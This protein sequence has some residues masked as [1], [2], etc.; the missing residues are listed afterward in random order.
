VTF[1]IVARD[2][3]SF[4]VA[5]ASKFLAAG[6]YVPAAEAGVGAV[7]SQAFSNLAYRPAGLAHLRQGRSAAETVAL[8][9]AGDDDRDTRQLGVVGRS[10]PGA[11]FTGANCHPWAGGRS[12]E[13]Y[14]VQGNIL[15]GEEVVLAMER[16]WLSGSAEVA[17][18]ATRFAW[19]LLHT[20]EAGDLAGG[21]RRGRQSAALLVASPGAGY[22][23]SDLAVD[24]RVDDHAQPVDELKRLL[25]L[26]DFYFGQPDPAS[27]L[28]LEGE[29]LDEVVRLLGLV[30][31]PPASGDGK[32][33]AE[34]LAE[35]A[36]MENLE[37]RYAGGPTLD[38]VVLDFLREK[39]SSGSANPKPTSPP[40]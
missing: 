37:M 21:D 9:T 3:D 30:G 5:V 35:W 14:A 24:L 2:G 17:N 11:T 25:S 34:A 40:P 32:A 12:G 8:L 16:A 38:P 33:V 20:L 13:G 19:R 36:S 31:F 7:A 6:A 10:G 22:G 29:I 39:A 1:S 23:G 27:L 28:A 15:A 26:H 18:T 4:G